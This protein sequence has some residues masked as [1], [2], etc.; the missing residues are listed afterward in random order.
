M[1]APGQKEG[2]GIG[3]GGGGGE[4]QWGHSLVS[5]DKTRREREREIPDTDFFFKPFWLDVK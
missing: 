1:L 5:E 3:G 4:P 2:E